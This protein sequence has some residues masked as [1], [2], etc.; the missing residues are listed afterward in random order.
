[1]TYKQAR[2]ELSRVGMAHATGA[3]YAAGNAFA[4]SFLT[5]LAAEAVYDW[6][7]KHCLDD[8]AKRQAFKDAHRRQHDFMMA[9]V[10]DE[11]LPAPE[12]ELA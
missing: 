6:T 3:T 2:K 4:I 7:V 9:V 12:T 1:M 11:P 5:G 8:R 10:N